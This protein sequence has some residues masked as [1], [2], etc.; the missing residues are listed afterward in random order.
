VGRS[1]SDER[2]RVQGE[3][4]VADV[5]YIGIGIGFF[6]LFFFYLAACDRL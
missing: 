6:V 2:N 3:T 1:Y 5:L 4:T